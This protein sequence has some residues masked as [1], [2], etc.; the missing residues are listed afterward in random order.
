MVLLTSRDGHAKGTVV[1]FVVFV[2]FG[3]LL[4]VKSVH[5]MVLHRRSLGW[6]PTPATITKL[7]V[8]T[9]NSRS[10]KSKSPGRSC[11]VE[12]NYT[13][14]DKHYQGN[15]VDPQMVSGTRK[16]CLKL[17]N[18]TG[19]GAIVVFYN[20]NNPEESMVSLYFSLPMFTLFAVVAVIFSIIGISGLIDLITGKKP[21]QGFSVIARYFLA[22]YASMYAGCLLSVSV[23]MIKRGFKIAILP[24]VI[25]SILCLVSVIAICSIFLPHIQ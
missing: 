3:T 5:T 25:G 9:I 13:I 18:S 15:R 6:K 11:R 20:P 21:L 4:S 10:R 22:V 19:E 7:G 17:L 16:F 2:V 24:L 1:I 8:A 14:D 23:D 12:F